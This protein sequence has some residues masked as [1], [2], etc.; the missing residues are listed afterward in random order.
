MPFEL[1]RNVSQER[2]EQGNTRS[3][4]HVQQP[5]LAA[6]SEFA[7]PTPQSLAE[8]YLNEPE[9][10]HAY[11]LGDAE[12]SDLSGASSSSLA[13]DESST[14][15]SRLR[16][17]EEKP[18]L[19]TTSVSY[20]QTYANL[21]IW[22]SGINI[23]VQENPLR[24]TSSHSSV[25]QDV[26]P[27]NKD[28]IVGAANRP[29][30]ITPVLL[31]N[32]LDLPRSTQLTING[33]R[34]LI[35]HYRA[36]DRHHP[37]TNE[38]PEM[39]QAGPPTLALPPV[40]DSVVEGTH[41]VVTEVLF[42][43]PMRGWGDLNWRAFIE[44]ETGAVLYLRAFVAAA[45]GSVFQV[46]PPTA[47]G[48]M[49]ITPT[50]GDAILNP[51]RTTVPLAGLASQAQGR[52]QPLKGVFVEL[53]DI[54]PP[55]AVPPMKPLPATFQYSAS[56]DDFSAVNAYYH[57][58]WLFRTVQG[59]GFDLSTYFDGTTFPV[60]VDHRAT[61][62]ANC[63]NGV[64]VNAQAPGNATGTGSDGFRFA[65][66]AVPQ[67]GGTTVGIAADVRV[68]LHEFG[69]VLLWDSVSS[70]NF[71]FAHS[72]GDSLA[73]V[74][75]DPDSQLRQTPDRFAT[76]PWILPN[77]RHDRDV[78][79]GWAW[80]GANDVGGY[81]SEQILSTTH[82]HLYRAIGG[83]ATNPVRR[84][85]A[86]RQVAYLIIRGIGSLAA[87]PITPTANARV[88]A[89]TLMNADIGTTDF[90]GYRG[91]SLH[92][93]IRWAFERQGLYPPPGA[94]RPVVQPGAPPDVDVYIDDGRQGQYPWQANFWSTTD[95]WN[96]LASD[97]GAAHQTPIVGVPNFAYVRIRNR[98]SQRADRVTVHGFH[99]KP[100][101][102]LVWPGDWQPMTT[103][104]INV[105]QGVPPA[106]SAVVGPFEWTP[107]FVGHECLLMSVSATGDLSNIDPAAA[108]PAAVGPTPEWQLTPFD[109]NLGQRNLAPV[110]GGGGIEGLRESFRQRKFWVKNPFAD[111][112]RIELDPSLPEVLATRNWTIRFQGMD[113][114]FSL[115]PGEEREVTVSLLPGRDFTAADVRNDP[116]PTVE[117]HTEADG[118][119]IG[120]MSYLLDPALT[121][122]P[123]ER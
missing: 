94:P 38:Q 97:S 32:L 108:S 68:V 47:T 30:D 83:D 123:R 82:F 59:M 67:A 10:K 1:T 110:A 75:I 105:P 102:G 43:M 119:V 18:L 25:H 87:S 53:V 70:P 71:G 5:Y 55:P 24:V 46:D 8:S 61:I 19:G 107:Q 13:T 57:C 44:P 56:T 64:C 80:G 115:A 63:A 35:Y 95:I 76:F 54:S 91:G 74:L 58:D 28:T 3:L 73:A 33:T 92:K 98:G 31:E 85:L 26:R 60:G 86:G 122:T 42:R 22:E 9:V 21:P 118:I 11:G 50:A 37:E 14:E 16:I 109:N 66:A 114:A 103:A 84:R 65:L 104:Q 49:G 2:D 79:G 27:V 40:P 72:A 6:A 117:I 77:R 4:D 89:T 69:H 81:N 112:V 51:L 78:A 36:T 113:G 62:G 23:T 90:E 96:R 100:A 88:W 7:V 41:Y 20:Q 12:L 116:N 45:S 17:G 48:N 93:V 111:R 15:D 121:H 52:P 99:C 120:G 101:T 29:E 34:F 39:M 106:G